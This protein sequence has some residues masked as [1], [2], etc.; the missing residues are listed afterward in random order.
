MEAFRAARSRW[1]KGTTTGRNVAEL[2]P[3]RV[4]QIALLKFDEDQ[5]VFIALGGV[6]KPHRDDAVPVEPFA[7]SAQGVCED[8]STDP[9]LDHPSTAEPPL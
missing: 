5:N 4:G 8:G 2:T 1:L 7:H 6:F 3:E 9:Y